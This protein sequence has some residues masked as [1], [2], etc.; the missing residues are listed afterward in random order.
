MSEVSQFGFRKYIIVF[1][2]TV[3]TDKVLQI[4]VLLMVLFAFHLMETGKRH[5]WVGSV[6]V[7]K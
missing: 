1:S 2:G 7:R 6:A 3:K 5:C 4:T